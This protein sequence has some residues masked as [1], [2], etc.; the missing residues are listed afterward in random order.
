MVPMARAQ[1]RPADIAIAGATCGYLIAASGL[2]WYASGGEAVLGIPVPAYGFK[3][4]RGLTLIAC[5]AA[6]AGI[7][8]VVLR[9]VGVRVPPR[10]D[11]AAALAGLALTLGAAAWPGGTPAGPARPAVGLWVGSAVAAAWSGAAVW[12][13]RERDT[14]SPSA[15]FERIARP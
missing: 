8:L 5:V 9:A 1:V 10:A 13:L 6:A 15:G 3:G 2:E 4:W 11:V 7:A 12:R 14:P